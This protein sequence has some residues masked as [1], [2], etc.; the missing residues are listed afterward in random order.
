MELSNNDFKEMSNT[1]IKVKLKE[2]ELEYQNVKNTLLK[3]CDDLEVLEKIYKS[4]EEE[5]KKRG[6]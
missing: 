3:L 6:L 5:L 1:N 2:I 4:G